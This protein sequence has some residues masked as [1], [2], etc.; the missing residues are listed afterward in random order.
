MQQHAVN[1]V[2]SGNVSDFSAYKEWTGYL[3]AIS[4]VY[5]TLD[6]VRK[7]LNSNLEGNTEYGYNSSEDPG[8]L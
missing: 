2:C 6:N 4:E 5:Q 7:R 8:S 1:I 3:R